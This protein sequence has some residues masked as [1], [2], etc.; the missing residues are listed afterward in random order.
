MQ[1]IFCSKLA[2]VSSLPRRVM[3]FLMS[4]YHGT[5]IQILGALHFSTYVLSTISVL[6]FSHA[7]HCRRQLDTIWSCYDTELNKSIRELFEIA[8]TKKAN[9]TISM[10]WY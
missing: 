9:N 3:Y 7:I 10:W 4:K 8:A 6:K 1:D 5:N 2:Y